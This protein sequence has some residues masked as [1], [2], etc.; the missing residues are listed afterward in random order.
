ME[1]V[2]S[3]QCRVRLRKAWNPRQA[4]MSVSWAQRRPSRK[5]K[6]KRRRH[7]PKAFSLLEVALMTLFSSCGKTFNIVMVMHVF[8]VSEVVSE[9]RAYPH[10]T[11]TR[12]RL[13]ENTS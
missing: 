9:T 3:D 12:V 7:G 4:I 1:T 11:L 5:Q 8:S 10:I 2:G 13:N 6:T